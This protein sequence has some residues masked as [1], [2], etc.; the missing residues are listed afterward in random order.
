[1]IARLPA[2]EHARRPAA[3]IARSQGQHVHGHQAQ[4]RRY[5]GR[6]RHSDRQAWP[7]ARRHVPGTRVT[8]GSTQRRPQNGQSGLVFTFRLTL[9]SCLSNPQ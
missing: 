5:R 6:H 9:F 3:V 4:R 8:A 7:V 1:M 2:A